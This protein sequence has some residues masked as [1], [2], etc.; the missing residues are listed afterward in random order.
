M[1]APNQAAPEGTAE[2]SGGDDGAAVSG[3]PMAE[4]VENYV[5]LPPTG[6]QVK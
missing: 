6:R 4:T 3:A 1:H 5:V 2:G